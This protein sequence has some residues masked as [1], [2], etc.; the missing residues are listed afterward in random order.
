MDG[1]VDL[2]DLVEQRGREF[3]QSSQ[4]PRTRS[5]RWMTEWRRLPRT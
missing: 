5:G 3:L 1:D 4:T 2:D